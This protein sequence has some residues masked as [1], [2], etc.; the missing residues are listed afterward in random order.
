METHPYFYDP[1]E[2]QLERTFQKNVIVNKLLTMTV[3]YAFI[4]HFLNLIMFVFLVLMFDM[5]IHAGI[6]MFT[7]LHWKYEYT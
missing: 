3:H 5:Y 2:I 7:W 6:K 1:I 4:F